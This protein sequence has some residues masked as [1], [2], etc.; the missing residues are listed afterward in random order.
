MGKKKYKK[1]IDSLDGE[2]TK[3]IDKFKEAMDRDDEGAMSYMA[4]EMDALIE[5]KK[6][7]EIKLLPRDK[8]I[9]LKKK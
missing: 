6:K 9:K 3:H 7:R 8:R 1:G 5:E 2:L 4:R